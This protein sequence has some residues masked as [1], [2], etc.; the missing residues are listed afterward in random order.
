[1]TTKYTPAPWFIV[2]GEHSG[3]EIRSDSRWGMVEICLVDTGFNEPIESEQISNANLIA[4]A[5]ELLE[6][7]KSLCE[8]YCESG[9]Y[10]SKEDRHRHRITLIKAR[11]AIAKALGETE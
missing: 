9:N 3:I 11:A 5:P 7:L 2:N 6:A 4:A 8:C 1:M 10:L